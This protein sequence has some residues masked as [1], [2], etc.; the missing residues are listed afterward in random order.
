[1]ICN[2]KAFFLAGPTPRST[3]VK[4]WRPEALEY[5]RRTGFDGDVLVPERKDWKV[6]FGYCDQVEWET[7]GLE[8]CSVVLFWVPR[9]MTTMPA[10]TTNV[11]FGM[12][13]KSDKIIYGRP[14]EAENV[15]YLDSLY[16]RW[17][18][19]PCY[20]IEQT[21]NAADKLANQKII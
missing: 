20:T 4:S 5:L 21:L 8:R 7:R 14:N 16:K 3:D 10:L 9:N 6:K 15:R 17:Q 19:E 13:I 11:E 1:M 18:G 2:L 12:Y